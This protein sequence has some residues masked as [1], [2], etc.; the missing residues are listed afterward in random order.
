VRI[1]ELEVWRER[2]F[3]FVLWL[4]L[5]FGAVPLLL[6]SLLQAERGR[7]HVALPLWG[8]YVVFIALGLAKPIPWRL[9]AWVFL[10]GLFAAG[11][12]PTAE[13]GFRGQGTL[14]MLATSVAGTVILGTRAGV[15]LLTLSLVVVSAFAALF[16]SGAIEGQPPHPVDSVSTWLSFVGTLVFLGVSLVGTVGVLMRRLEQGVV[17]RQAQVEELRHEVKVVDAERAATTRELDERVRAE[18]LTAHRD[19]VLEAASFATERLL[20]SRRWQDVVGEIVENLGAAT[21][22]ERVTLAEVVTRTD[23]QAIAVRHFKAF[24]GR[25]HWA[26]KAEFREIPVAETGIDLFVERLARGETVLVQDKRSPEAG[27]ALAAKLNIGTGIALP[28]QADGRLWGFI[29]F[30][31]SDRKYS[32][33]A[34]L[35][36]ILQS[37]AQNLG[38]AIARERTDAER[39]QR[40]AEQ[41]ERLNQLNAELKAFSYTVSHD[42]RAPVRQVG[43]FAEMLRESSGDALGPDG[44]KKLDTIDGATRRMASMIDDLLKFHAVGWLTITRVEVDLHE[45]VEEV[46]DE[47]APGARGREVDWNLAK[48]PRFFADRALLKQVF[49]NLIDNALKY[50]RARAR[51]E[52]HVGHRAEPG[53][54]VLFV[55]DNGVGFDPNYTHRLFQVFQRLHSAHDFEGSGIGLA[56]VRRIAERHG[57]RV[58]AEGEV[59]RGATFFVALRNKTSEPPLERVSNPDEEE[60]SSSHPRSG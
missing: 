28:V 60:W 6:W 18:E 32:L 42:L 38:T 48:L 54:L 44:L 47:L 11:V 46:I 4:T 52:I 35:L 24:E 37:A 36:D 19:R 16:I 59:D 56:H 33:R 25:H 41:E 15:I 51:T 1:E 20:A 57:G 43:A 3:R 5:A 49:L 29:G 21:G 22:V 30:E 13:Y 9:R 45:L 8:V 12:I 40:L 50:T 26:E 2:A 27:A 14:L 39:D 31:S 17:V 58:W 53:E 23:G 7:V 10:A 34:P 55:R